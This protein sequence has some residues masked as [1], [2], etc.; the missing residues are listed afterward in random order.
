LNKN[1]PFP[2]S[3]IEFKGEEEMNIE[4]VGLITYHYSHP[5]GTLAKLKKV[6]PDRKKSIKIHEPSFWIMICILKFF[7]FTQA[8]SFLCNLIKHPYRSS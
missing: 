5:L 3:S 4:T 1:F 8:K 6:L 7:D 2:K